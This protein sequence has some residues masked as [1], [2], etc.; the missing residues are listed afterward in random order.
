MLPVPT[1]VMEKA[2]S[3]RATKPMLLAIIYADDGP[4]DQILSAYRLAGNGDPGAAGDSNVTEVNASLDLATGGA[5]PLDTTTA[6]GSPML[7]SSWQ[8]SVKELGGWVWI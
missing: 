5:V 2:N 7:V 6:A 8:G 4:N 3:Q 1:T